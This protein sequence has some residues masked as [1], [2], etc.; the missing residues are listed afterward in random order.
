[1]PEW[2]PLAILPNLTIDDPLD[3]GSIALVAGADA[4]L[5]P[6]NAAHPQ[7][8][9]LLSRFNNC[10]GIP[11]RPAVLIGRR[12]ILDG[13]GRPRAVVSFR[14]ILAM[15]VVP[16]V[17]ATHIVYQGPRP[18]IMYSTSFWLHPWMLSRDN[19]HIATSTP[20]M[21]GLHTVDTF[22]GQSSPELS[23]LPLDRID[24]PL[25]Q[26]L[27]VRW[28]RHYLGRGAQLWEDRALFRSL[29][30]AHQAALL[31]GATDTT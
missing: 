31:P 24:R 2:H 30:M 18:G 11:L 8:P 19:E 29:N 21:L 3:G 13:R 9:D 6:F 28:N 12:R 14:D 20:A 17:R 10:L 4:R 5:S 25:F 16:Y 27:L 15:S 22:H 26:A 7:F 1:M 23:H